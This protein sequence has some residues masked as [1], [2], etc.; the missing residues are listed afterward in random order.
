MQHHY[1]SCPG[2]IL[3]VYSRPS[4]T[5]R[6]R[7]GAV[8][9]ASVGAALLAWSSAVVRAQSPKGDASVASTTAS[10]KAKSQQ[11]K[12]P[13]RQNVTPIAFRSSSGDVSA[14]TAQYREVL[15]RYC[16]VCHNQ[17]LRSA[18]L[19][20]EILDVEI[21]PDRAQVWE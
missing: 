1:G 14:A 13:K 2:P 11:L 20:L 7:S 8:L 19:T 10:E 3:D 6:K 15:N 18:G 9:L 4:L 5:M 17:Q 12:S 21:V 16:V